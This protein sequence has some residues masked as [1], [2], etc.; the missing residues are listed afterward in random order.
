M[1]MTATCWGMRATAA[2]ALLSTLTLFVGFLMA[3]ADLLDANDDQRTMPAPW[4][5]V[6]LALVCT[7]AITGAV[8]APAARSGFALL[9]GI[10]ALGL[11]RPTPRRLGALVFAAWC[12]WPVLSTW[13]LVSDR[14]APHDLSTFALGVLAAVAGLTIFLG[15]AAVAARTNAAMSLPHASIN[16]GARGRRR[17]RSVAR[18]STSR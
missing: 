7:L 5:R 11:C 13:L 16:A 8:A 18:R 17:A 9:A 10:A 15:R 3:L 1:I 2:L 14:L 12:A 6:V 4:L